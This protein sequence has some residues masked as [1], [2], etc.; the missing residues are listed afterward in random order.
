MAYP[1]RR[2]LLACTHFPR[3]PKP[4]GMSS[5]WEGEEAPL[6]WVHD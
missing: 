1:D 3:E 5:G 4:T 6:P 2:R